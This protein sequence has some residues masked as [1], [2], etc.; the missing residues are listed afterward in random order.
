[1]KGDN[2]NEISNAELFLRL[3][4]EIKPYLH[5]IGAASDSILKEKVSKYPVFT[6]SQEEISV[7]VKLVKKGGRSGRWNVFASTLEEF[8]SKGLV[9]KSRASDFIATYKDPYTFICLFVVSELGAQFIFMPRNLED[10]NFS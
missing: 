6:L 7:G 2:S 1:M 4:E 8:V 5:L 3:R 10:E 9:Q